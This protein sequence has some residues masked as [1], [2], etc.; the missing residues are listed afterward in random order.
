MCTSSI[1]QIT[2]LILSWDISQLTEETLM[3]SQIL[4]RII[5]SFAS[6][7]PANK[8]PSHGLNTLTRNS[9]TSC[10]GKEYSLTSTL[11]RWRNLTKIPY[12][13]RVF[14]EMLS[15]M[16]IMHSPNT[17]GPSLIAQPS[18]NMPKYTF[19]QASYYLVYVFEGFIDKCLTHYNLNPAHYRSTLRFHHTLGTRCCSKPVCIWFWRLFEADWHVTGV[20]RYIVAN[21]K[22]TREDGGDQDSWSASSS[23]VENDDDTYLCIMPLITFTLGQYSSHSHMLT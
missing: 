22:F 20:P 8:W 23:R 2:I 11:N 14:S 3:C 19:R 9:L 10:T 16:R 6:I 13:Q 21:D 4:R 7:L 1:C 18:N 5:W 15:K 12:P 17:S